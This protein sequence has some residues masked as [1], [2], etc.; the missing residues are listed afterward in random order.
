M[1]KTFTIMAV[2]L[3]ALHAHTATAVVYRAIPTREAQ[4]YV[5]SK[6]Q[7][8]DIV[9]LGTTHRQPPILALMA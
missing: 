8:H 3:M 6:L 9:F 2:M 1:S 7:D 4:E 5:I